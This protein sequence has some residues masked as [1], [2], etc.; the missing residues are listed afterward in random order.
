MS[1]YLS[2]EWKV[3][4][5]RALLHYGKKCLKCGII[6]SEMHVDHIKPISLYPDLKEDMNNLQVLCKEC[7]LE[8]SNIHTT[9][10]RPEE[11]KTK[12][13][14]EE[15]KVIKLSTFKQET[16]YVL[17][18]DTQHIFSKKDTLCQLSKN[19]KKKPYLIFLP[20]QDYDKQI[21]KNCL[22]LKRRLDA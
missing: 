15:P 2:L 6:D 8:K 10:Y 20:R 7:N 18:K 21:C 4:R 14:P 16:R 12:A 5:Y 3:L 19:I 22:S 1:F 17:Y 11:L 9:D 13:F